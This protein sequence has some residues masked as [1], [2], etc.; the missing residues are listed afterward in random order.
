M[1]KANLV[2]FAECFSR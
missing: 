1:R 2:K